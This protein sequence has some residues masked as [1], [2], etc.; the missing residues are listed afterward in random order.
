MS[1][2]NQADRSPVER[3]V[4]RTWKALRGCFRRDHAKPARPITVLSIW[5][6]AAGFFIVVRQT[7]RD[8]VNCGLHGE[9]RGQSFYWRDRCFPLGTL[10]AC[11]HDS[12]LLREVLGFS[13][14]RCHLRLTRP[15]REHTT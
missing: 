12:T 4:R 14:K 15:D 1:R 9:C 8:S 3:G 2:D 7:G 13:R 6:I 10:V 11:S 5:E